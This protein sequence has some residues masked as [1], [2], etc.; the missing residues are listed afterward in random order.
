MSGSVVT[1]RI[2][3]NPYQLGCDAGQEAEIEALGKMVDETVS[4]LA[5]SVGQIG[6]SRLLVMAAILLAEQC[7][8]NGAVSAPASKQQPQDTFDE[9]QIARLENVAKQISDLAASLK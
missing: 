7:K 2:N 3:G 8:A 6:E 4:S 1:I 9:A 5:A